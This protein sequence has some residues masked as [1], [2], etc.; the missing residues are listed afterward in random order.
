[1]YTQKHNYTENTQIQKQIRKCKKKLVKRFWK[2]WAIMYSKLQMFILQ[3]FCCHVSLSDFWC[4]ESGDL[5]S[6]YN[7]YITTPP[8]I[9]HKDKEN[10]SS[11]YKLE[12]EEDFDNTHF[13][14]TLISWINQLLLHQKE[15]GILYLSI[16]RG[17]LTMS[18]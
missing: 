3:H 13:Y 17:L 1:M 7:R 16:I 8:C 2:C 6:L 4:T 15:Q 11:E 18:S 14:S 5:S 10:K 9:Y 12:T